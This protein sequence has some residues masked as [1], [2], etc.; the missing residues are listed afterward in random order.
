M[1]KLLLES[2]SGKCTALQAQPLLRAFASR[3]D[4]ATVGRL[5]SQGK[6]AM[7]QASR[8]RN[9]LVAA[10]VGEERALQGSS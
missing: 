2:W 9:R 6:G 5:L 7:V 1:T 8:R 3:G 4:A 10:M